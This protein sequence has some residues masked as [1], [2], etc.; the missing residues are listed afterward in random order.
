MKIET[1]DTILEEIKSKYKHYEYGEMRHKKGH[2]TF[3]KELD[4]LKNPKDILIGIFLKLIEENPDFKKAF[5]IG[6]IEHKIDEQFQDINLYV[7]FDDSHDSSTTI[8]H[9]PKQQA[10]NLISFIEKHPNY[11]LYILKEAIKDI[12]IENKEDLEKFK[13]FVDELKEKIGKTKTESIHYSELNKSERL[14]LKKEFKDF[15][16][17]M[18]KIEQDYIPMLEKK[19]DGKGG[20]GWGT[21]P[22]M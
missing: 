1:L 4:E 10:R 18:E 6:L 19:I 3:E 15:D 22:T 7:D 2:E 8:T 17:L 16:V 12:K 21:P 5:S 9:S 11:S 20:D 14:T 13:E